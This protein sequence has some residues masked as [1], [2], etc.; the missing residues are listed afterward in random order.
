MKVAIRDD[1]TSFFTTP[2]ALERVYGDVFA[3]SSDV[4]NSPNAVLEAMA[5]GLPVVATDAGGVRD[6]VAGPGGVMVPPGDAPALAQALERYLAQP[7]AAR[8]AGVFN[9]SRVTAEF[10]WRTSALHLLGVYHRVLAARGA[11]ERVK[12]CC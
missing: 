7:D 12:T 5:C 4:D 9:R 11:G 6:F 8:A 1:D 3:L 10:S 2:E